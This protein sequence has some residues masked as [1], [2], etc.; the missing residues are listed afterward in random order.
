MVKAEAGV[1]LCGRTK[2]QELANPMTRMVVL[3]GLRNWATMVCRYR[4]TSYSAD[5]EDEAP[6][7]LCAARMP[8][9]AIGAHIDRGCPPPKAKAQLNGTGNQ[10]SDW[11]K[12][13][14]G[15][16]SAKSKEYV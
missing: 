1:H 7:P 9:S 11:R 12:V 6:C 10:K 16:G 5:R 13:F 15:A 4:W 3:T 14:S 8:I 2:M